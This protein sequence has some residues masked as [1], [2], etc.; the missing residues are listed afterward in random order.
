MPVGMRRARGAEKGTGT[1]CTVAAHSKSSAELGRLP[2]EN[3]VRTQPTSLEPEAALK[4]KHSVMH[5]CQFEISIRKVIRI[6]LV[7]ILNSLQF[8][9]EQVL[10]GVTD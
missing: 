2:D 1:G 3:I 10:R 7:L 9:L 8:L 6:P 4:L 5:T